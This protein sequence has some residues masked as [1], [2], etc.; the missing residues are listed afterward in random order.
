[1]VTLIIGGEM[2][3]F[4]GRLEGHISLEKS[5]TLGFGYDPVFIPDGF[6]GRTLAE[7][8]ED[9]K[10]SI[11][12]RGKSLRAMAAWMKEEGIGEK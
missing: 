4:E 8:G 6:G 2:H 11:S 9:I 10:N 1:M 5:G 3:F 7:L 12:H